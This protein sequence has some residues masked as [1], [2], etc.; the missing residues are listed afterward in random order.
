MPAAAAEIGVAAVDSEAPAAT[1][2]DRAVD[3]ALQEREKSAEQVAAMLARREAEAMAGAGAAWA[4]AGGHGGDEGAREDGNVDVCVMCQVRVR[5][6][7]RGWG[8]YNGARALASL[9]GP[10]CEVREQA[11]IAVKVA[12]LDAEQTSGSCISLAPVSI[13]QSSAA[14]IGACLNPQAPGDDALH[15]K[16]KYLLR[17]RGYG[18]CAQTLFGHG[19]LARRGVGRSIRR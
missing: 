4:G 6:R 17:L 10:A 16:I 19:E 5:A 11:D 13:V 1:A 7:G 15:F 18:S 12:V 2:K 8:C 9:C 14:R 3:R